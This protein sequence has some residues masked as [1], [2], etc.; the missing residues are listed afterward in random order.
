MKGQDTIEKWAPHSRVDPHLWMQF[1]Y[2]NFRHEFVKRLGATK[3]I[4]NKY[5]DGI[6][7][8]DPRRK[9]IEH[10]QWQRVRNWGIPI[11]LHGD[12]VDCNGESLN[13]V[14]WKSIVGEGVT[15]DTF[16]P[17]FS[18]FQSTSVPGMTKEIIWTRL[19][20]S[21]LLAETGKDASGRNL[22]GG[23]F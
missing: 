10:L 23:F 13:S 22:A 9:H 20:K 14:Q 2:D 17:C 12:G 21:L 4:L 16:Y 11:K 5:W 8:R 7:P 1:I 6:N 15:I 3:Q 18:Y 19:V